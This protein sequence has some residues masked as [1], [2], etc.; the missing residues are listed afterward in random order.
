MVEES[1]QIVVLNQIDASSSHH[2][3][4][5]C[6]NYRDSTVFL[7]SVLLTITEVNVALKRPAWM[8]SKYF[9]SHAG[10][11]VDG[12]KYPHWLGRSCIHTA[13]TTGRPWWMVDLG[14]VFNV[15][16]VVVYNRRDNCCRKILNPLPAKWFVV[17]LNFSSDLIF[18]ELQ[19]RSKLLI[20]IYCMSVKK[21]N[22]SSE[23]GSSCI[24]VFIGLTS[25]DS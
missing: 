13:E 11:A 19:C 7:V 8:S 14:H 24:N 3:R 16:S 2:S 22:A 25:C 15:A 23:S 4:Y 20:I 17:C 9:W 1:N 21:L 5:P 10:L 18:K 6:S 12:N